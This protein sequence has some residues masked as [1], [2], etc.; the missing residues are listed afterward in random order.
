MIFRIRLK[1]LFRIKG[2]LMPHASCLLPSAFYPSSFAFHLPPSALCLVKTKMPPVG[3]AS[4]KSFF[5][6][7]EVLPL[8]FS[9]F[10][11]DFQWIWIIRFLLVNWIYGLLMDMDNWYSKSIAQISHLQ[12]KVTGQV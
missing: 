6:W 1:I 2:F 8:R 4:V 7:V 3:V 9:G 11:G 12:S 5:L 10:F